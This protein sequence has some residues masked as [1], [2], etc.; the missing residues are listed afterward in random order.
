MLEESNLTAATL[1]ET[2]SGLLG[3]GAGLQAMAA[4]AR[5]LSHPSAARDIAALAASVAGIQS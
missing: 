1:I 2:I 3:D 5:K 4:A